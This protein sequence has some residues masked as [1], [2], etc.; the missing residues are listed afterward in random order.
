LFFFFFSVSHWSGPLC[1]CCIDF[2]SYFYVLSHQWHFRLLY[3]LLNFERLV[4]V[5][6]KSRN[7][8]DDIILFVSSKR[9]RSETRN[10]A[11]TLFFFPLQIKKRSSL[12]NKRAGVLRKAFQARKIFGTFEKRA[13]IEYLLQWGLSM[14]WKF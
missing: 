7:F 4:P 8:S 2:Q 5:S 3:S 14:K 12:Q 9:R 1:P 6:R 11:V 10:F 13:P